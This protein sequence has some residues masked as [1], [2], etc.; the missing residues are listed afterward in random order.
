MIIHIFFVFSK[1]FMKHITL[2]FILLA[3]LSLRPAMA[4]EVNSGNDREQALLEQ[5]EIHS[6]AYQDLSVDSAILYQEAALRMASQIQAGPKVSF[7][8]LRQ[9]A[10][11][12]RLHADFSQALNY[13]LKALKIAESLNDPGLTGSALNNTGIDYYRMGQLE[14]A[15]DYYRKGLQARLRTTDT[16]SIADSYY[17]LGMILDD[18]NN[19]SLALIQ[20]GIALKLFSEIGRCDGMADVYNG[21]AGYHYKR[22]RI[23]SCIEYLDLAIRKYQECGNEEARSF[24]SINLA[25]L[26]NMQGKHREAEAYLRS[27]I[28]I[29]RNVGLLSQLR[30][31]YKSLSETYSYLGDYKKAYE[32][33][34]TC[35]IYKDSIFNTERARAFEELQTQ[36]ETEKKERIILEK[37]TEISFKEQEAASARARLWWLAGLSLMALVLAGLILWR[38]LEKRRTSRILDRQNRE[39]SQ[40]NATKD[41]FFSI[42][43]HDLRS[44]LSS[45]EKIT[46][47]L[48]GSVDH[49]SREDMAS[50][51]D[52]LNR[53]SKGILSLLNNLLQWSMCQSGKMKA[54]PDKLHIQTLCGELTELLLPQAGLRGV[55]IKSN[56]SG[57]LCAFA[58]QRMVQTI[59]RN[60]LTNAV[61]FTRDGGQVEI[62]AFISGDKICI[63]IADEGPG[64]TA[65]EI[66]LLFRIDQDISRIGGGDPRKGAG[67][68]LILSM[69][70]ARLCEGAVRISIN[71]AGGLNADLLLP[72]W[73][74]QNSNG[75]HQNRIG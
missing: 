32:A 6:R 59:I 46:A 74:N 1:P 41:K 10:V 69:E 33:L 60:L 19:D 71:D 47:A 5:Y 68:G 20:Y 29:A 36:Y 23:D 66:A 51:L 49:L 26:L 22:A 39:L 35:N 13:D 56:I 52:E 45:F 7:R 24:M 48:L 38:F 61:K 65:D 12:W 73:Q 8:I 62:S 11:L 54:E 16:L 15:A 30:Q 44:P 57:D 75:S 3:L 64:L 4:Q 40:L 14:R 42:L 67:L 25:S 50:Y 31:G 37:E 43:S 2:L 28:E 58:D 9:L 70:L 18:L 72:L 55:S 34:L 53:S 27:G 21:L 17:N 63:R